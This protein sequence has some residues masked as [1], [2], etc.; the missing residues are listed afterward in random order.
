[1]PHVVPS[2]ETWK[3]PA[4]ALATM[5]PA[6]GTKPVPVIE[7]VCTAELL[8]VGVVPKLLNEDAV[9][10]IVGLITYKVKSWKSP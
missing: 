5:L 10:V 3:P 2:A 9:E 8:H 7:N 1:M 4:G 6:A